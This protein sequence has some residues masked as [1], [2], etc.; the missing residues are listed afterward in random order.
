VVAYDIEPD[1]EGIRSGV[2]KM[3][4]LSE[5]MEAKLKEFKAK[6]NRIHIIGNPPW[7]GLEE[8]FI[9][10]CC[11]SAISSISFIL[12]A[13]QMRSDHLDL[14]LNE[15]GS[16]HTETFHLS[17]EY[18]PIYKEYFG[19][20]KYDGLPSKK[21]SCFIVWKCQGIENGRTMYKMPPLKDDHTSRFLTYE[22]LLGKDKK[23][24]NIRISKQSAKCERYEGEGEGVDGKMFYYFHVAEKKSSVKTPAQ[25]G[26]HLAAKFNDFKKHHPDVFEEM[27]YPSNVPSLSKYDILKALRRFLK[28]YDV[29]AAEDNCVSSAEVEVEKVSAYQM[30][31]Y[32]E[33][34]FK[35][36]S[37]PQYYNEPLKITRDGRVFRCRTEDGICGKFLGEYKNGEIGDFSS[38]DD[39]Y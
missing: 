16:K 20:E 26:K 5:Q 17:L 27:S 30:E 1:A 2:E 11:K 39:D 38:E 3:D 8:K 34:G 36:F 19:E 33:D 24:A 6:H 7:K 10:Q 9:R 13:T 4:F 23:R 32:D 22:Y 28:Y 35:S 15:D 21:K 12:P 25:L 14:F 31:E 37:S 29:D 18:H